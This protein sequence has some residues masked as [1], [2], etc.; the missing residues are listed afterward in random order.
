MKKNKIKILF[1]GTPFFSVPSLEAL[2][3]SELCELIGIVTQPDRPQGRGQKLKPGAVKE[4]A[5][6]NKIPCFQFQSINSS[7]ALNELKKLKPSLIFVVSFGQILSEEILNLSP[8]G[9]LNA[10]ASLLP[11]YR[12]AAPI[13]WVLIRGEK[14]T[15]VCIIK[16]IK[17]LDAGPVVIQEKVKISHN[18]NYETLYKKLASL[19]AK[20]ILKTLVLAQ[21]NQLKFQEQDH[22]KATYAPKIEKT[23]CHINWNDKASH[24]HNFIRGLSPIPCA[25]TF[26]EGQRF[27]VYASQISKIKANNKPGTIEECNPTGIL[28]N[29]QDKRLFLTEIQLE[30]KKKMSA[31]L[32][33]QGKKLKKGTCLG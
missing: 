4:Y 1:L 10:H 21:K 28:V 5:L 31:S 27:K 25:F 19:S 6:K 18:D 32:F 3:K 9:C 29:T 30:N 16:L 17:K 22:N 13:N 11:Q 14:E 2:H 24:I 20:L 15:G 26:F 12:G 7:K 8:L 33:L 23:Q